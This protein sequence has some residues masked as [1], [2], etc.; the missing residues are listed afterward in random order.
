MAVKKA[1]EEILTRLEPIKQKMPE[2]SWAEW[3][4]V[5]YRDRISLSATGTVY[6]LGLLFVSFLAGL[7]QNL[8]VLGIFLCPN[9]PKTISSIFDKYPDRV[10]TKPNI[11]QKTLFHILYFR[12]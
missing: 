9:G 8:S 1:C 3:I 4:D 10:T 7:G 6:I 11:L 12:E 5:A 2:K